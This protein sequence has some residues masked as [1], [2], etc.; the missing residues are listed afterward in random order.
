LARHREAVCRLC[1]R[2]G[3]KLFLKG[4]RCF[5]EK[6]A[7]EKRNFVPGQHG[8]SRRV[9]KLAAECC[10]GRM[11]A[12]LEGGYDLEALVASGR[13]VLEELGRY[14]DEPIQPARNGAAVMPIVERAARNLGRFW[15]L[16]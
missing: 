2:E 7:I 1:R 13:A 3:Q 16:A 12:A 4:L 14:A 6:C 15:N 10:Q 8:Q 9:K 5:T 11:V